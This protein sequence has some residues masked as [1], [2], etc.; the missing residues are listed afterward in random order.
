MIQNRSYLVQEGSHE[1]V[2][3][4]ESG[5]TLLPLAVRLRESLRVAPPF[6]GRAERFLSFCTRVA[7]NW[8][9]FLFSL[10]SMNSRIVV[11]HGV[12]GGGPYWT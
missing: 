11:R 3:M 1:T 8:R 9:Y 10:N 5:L 7:L 12:R 6:Q 4:A 2:P